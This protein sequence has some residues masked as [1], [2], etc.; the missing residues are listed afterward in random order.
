MG[1]KVTILGTNL[2]GSTGVSFNGTAAAFTVVSNSQITTTVPT[3]ATTGTVEVVTPKKTLK[4]NA[5][6]HILR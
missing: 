2:T 1:T 5:V 3:G 4:S 6:F